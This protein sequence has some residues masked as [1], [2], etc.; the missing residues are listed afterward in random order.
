LTKALNKSIKATTTKNWSKIEDE[1]VE[2]QGGGGLDESNAILKQALGQ[3]AD[4]ATGSHESK[5]TGGG[6]VRKETLDQLIAERDKFKH[7]Y[8][9]EVKKNNNSKIVIES[10][11]RLID[12]TK[13]ESKVQGKYK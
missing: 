5:K 11:K 7:M 9:A 2:Y 13:I 4:S 10:Q 1:N 12:R 6:E 8:Q 3:H